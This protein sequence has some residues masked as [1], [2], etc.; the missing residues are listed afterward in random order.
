MGSHLLNSVRESAAYRGFIEIAT[1]ALVLFGL[2]GM[3]IATYRHF[4]PPDLSI[5]YQML[6]TIKPVHTKTAW[7]TA[8]NSIPD[9]LS[10][11]KQ[12]I[13][14]FL[15]VTQIL[16]V[17]FENNSRMTITDIALSLRLAREITDCAVESRDLLLIKRQSEICT[18]AER[19]DGSFVFESIGELPPHAGFVLTIWGSFGSRE[20]PAPIDVSSSANSNSVRRASLITGVGLYLAENLFSLTVTFIFFIVLA[21]A[22]RLGRKK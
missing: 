10:T 7:D 22:V 15:G 2:L 11:L 20:Q 12:Q 13:S 17:T 9:S 5:T 8:S 1:Q 3:G 16:R 18:Y 14:K 19:E 6:D 21:I 4:T